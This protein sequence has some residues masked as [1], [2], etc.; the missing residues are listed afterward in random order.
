MSKNNSGEI[1]DN[2]TNTNTMKSWLSGTEKLFN[3]AIKQYDPTGSAK[4]T[5]SLDCGLPNNVVRLAGG[6][7]TGC[8]IEWISNL[9][10]VPVD[11]TLNVCNSAIYELG[12]NHLSIENFKDS[13]NKTKSSF[14][15]KGY[16][17]NFDFMGNHKGNHFVSIANDDIENKLYLI[18]HS[19]ASEYKKD[20]DKGLYPFEG[21]WFYDDIQLLRTDLRYIR[22]LVGPKA[23]KFIDIAKRLKE[24]NEIRLDYFAENF[25]KINGLNE[26]KKVTNKSHYGLSSNNYELTKKYSIH[27]GCFENS[28]NQ[29]YPIFSKK[30]DKIFMFKSSKDCDPN[31]PHGFGKTGNISNIELTSDHKALNLGGIEYLINYESTTNGMIR[32]ISTDINDPN[33][34]FS[35]INGRLKGEIIKTLTPIY[36]SDANG[37]HDFT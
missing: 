25:C 31:I 12:N 5:T 18:L 24:Y 14:E 15:N 3:K 32:D 8:N 27:I 19:S 9:P 21:N 11:T 23:Q 30:G 28:Q 20:L 2:K 16:N 35:L 6:F 1:F 17:W 37:I 29:I 13:L 4:I 36:S 10:I 7:L 33:S 34:F 26:V 22:Y